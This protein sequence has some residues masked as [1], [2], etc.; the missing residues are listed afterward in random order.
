MKLYMTLYYIIN[1]ENIS[2][3]LHIIRE[4]GFIFQTSMALKSKYI[5][6]ILRKLYIFDI[7]IANLILQEFYLTNTII[8]SKKLF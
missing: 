3:F 5:K 2:L 4:V 6:T 1:N 7:K 8:N